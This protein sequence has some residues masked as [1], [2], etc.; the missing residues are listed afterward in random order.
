[1]IAA[2]LLLPYHVLEK[3]YRRIVEECHTGSTEFLNLLYRQI[4]YHNTRPLTPQEYSRSII[5]TDNCCY[6][7]SVHFTIAIVTYFYFLSKTNY[8]GTSQ[9]YLTSLKDSLQVTSFQLGPAS[10]WMMGKSTDRW[11][12]PQSAIKAQQSWSNIS[13]IVIYALERNISFSLRFSCYESFWL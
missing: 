10:R 11:S 2:Q 6:L 9:A 3:L 4:V 13:V 8:E 7:L 12:L 1:M 5:T